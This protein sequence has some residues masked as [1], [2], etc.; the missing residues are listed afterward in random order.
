MNQARQDLD[1]EKMFGLALDREKPERYRKESPLSIRTAA[2]C[3]EKC[4]R[5]AS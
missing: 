5:C 4:V 1:W 3:A 2:P